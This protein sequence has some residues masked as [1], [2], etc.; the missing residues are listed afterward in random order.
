MNLDILKLPSSHSFCE[1]KYSTLPFI[2]EFYNTITGVALCLSSYLFYK[3]NK[4]LTGKLNRYLYQANYNLF[5]VGVGTI[6]FHGTLLYIFQL[7]DEIPML[8]MTFDYIYILLSITKS[9]YLYFY[10]TKYL[11]CFIIIISY[12]V[13]PTLQIIVFF[14]SF[15]TNVCFIILLLDKIQSKYKSNSTISKTYYL[16]IIGCII[17]L[18]WIS[19]SLFCRYIQHFYL[20]SIWHIVTSILIYAFN[21]LLKEYVKEYNFNK[22]V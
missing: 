17:L 14:T 2:A 13:H 21:D 5:I 1:Y 8:L 20:H 6:F 12:W 19:D 4:K 22:I 15:T 18:I 16:L 10:Y 7:F 3:N 9:N 11:L